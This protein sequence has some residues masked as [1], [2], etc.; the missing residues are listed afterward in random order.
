[1]RA[2]VLIDTGPLVAIFSSRD[3]HHQSCVEELRRLAPPLLTCWPV[4]IEAAWLL[5]HHWPSGQRLLESFAAGWLRLLP[6][7]EADAAGLAKILK[8]YR[9]LGAQLADA[10]LVHLAERE[11]LETVFTLDRRDFSVYRLS[12]NR[13]LH[14]LPE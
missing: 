6:L 9:K 3:A 8:R 5:R 1:M 10:A 13:S 4:M 11:Q 14:L 12:G 2:G 7:S